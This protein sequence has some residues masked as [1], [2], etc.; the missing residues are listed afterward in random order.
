MSELGNVDVYLTAHF[1]LVSRKCQHGIERG[2]CLS[3]ECVKHSDIPVR[4][5]KSWD[6]A[7]QPQNAGTFQNLFQWNSQFPAPSGWITSFYRTLGSYG[8]TESPNLSRP[9][10][11]AETRQMPVIGYR[12]W[13]ATKQLGRGINGRYMKGDS[14]VALNS[15]NGGEW[16]RRQ[17]T[18]AKCRSYNHAAPNYHCECG[19]YVLTDL[20]AAPKWYGGQWPEGVI[21]GAVIGWGKVIQHGNE[22]WRAEYARPIGFLDTALFKDE[23][24]LEAAAQ[25]YGVPILERR[26]LQ[27]LAKEYGD[28]L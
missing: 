18:R 16:D 3:L 13:R 5:E 24:L 6:S 9:E 7:L 4:G 1:D 17:V 28:R 26:A 11:E 20:S 27:L 19:L 23:P 15:L 14:Q 22:G 8:L 2:Q 25:Q 12:G 21:V 10:P